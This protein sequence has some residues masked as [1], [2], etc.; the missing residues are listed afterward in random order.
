MVE[1]LSGRG[2]EE[3][4]SP[5]LL[6]HWR[7]SDAAS[8]VSGSSGRAPLSA[9][10]AAAPPIAANIP[11]VIKLVFFHIV[12]AG[13]MDHFTSL[14]QRAAFATSAAADA[15]KDWE[16]GGDTDPVADTAWEAGEATRAA[17]DAVAGIDAALTLDTYPE[18]RLGRLVMAAYL[19]VLAGTDEGG[20]SA[21][22]EMAAN[23]LQVAECT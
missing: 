18:T 7:R 13:N 6:G 16:N 3:S 21:D 14:L 12:I 9:L 1:C 20:Y 17:L 23:L 11:P 22:L 2:Q 4:L 15:C 8:G 19:L 5:P 10:W